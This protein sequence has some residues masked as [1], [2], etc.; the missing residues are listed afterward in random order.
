MHFVIAWY[1]PSLIERC[2]LDVEKGIGC[3]L[4]LLHWCVLV[5]WRQK[6]DRLNA[7]DPYGV[8]NVTN[9]CRVVTRIL[10]PGGGHN[11]ALLNLFELRNA[12]SQMNDQMTMIVMLLS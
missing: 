12:C 8:F 4:I 3:W 6:I 11:R 10:V 9:G 7:L 5:I 2:Q 1:L